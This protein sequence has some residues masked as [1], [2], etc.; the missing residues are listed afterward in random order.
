MDEHHYTVGQ[1]NSIISSVLTNHAQDLAP[2]Q[3]QQLQGYAQQ[4]NANPGYFQQ[5][6]QAMQSLFNAILSIAAPFII[7]YG[8]NHLMNRGQG[9]Q[10]GGQAGGGIFGGGGGQGGGGGLFG[11]GQAGGSIGSGLGGLIAAALPGIIGGLLGGAASNAIGGGS[12]GGGLFGGQPSGTPA[13]PV[14]NTGGTETV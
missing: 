5:N 8:I 12:Q 14:G 2:D 6:P 7:G 1:L 13:S 11:G 10:A 9:G 3:Q 4:L